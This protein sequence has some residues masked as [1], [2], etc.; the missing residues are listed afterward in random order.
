VIRLFSAH[1][2][3]FENF[4]NT[5]STVNNSVAISG[6]NANHNYRI[7]LSDLRNSDI[8][9]NATF[10]VTGLDAKTHSRFGDLTVDLAVNYSYQKST[11]RPYVGGNNGN[12]FYSLMYLPSNIDQKTL[13]SGIDSSGEELIYSQSI[14]N[15]YFVVNYQKWILRSKF[16]S[17]S[18]AKFTTY[19]D[20]L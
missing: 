5:G 14:S 16:T 1:K 9:P 20:L 8:I 18:V 10:S 4:F 17:I 12:Q 2:H 13:S 3:N 15:P 7:S 19:K 11:G 6:S